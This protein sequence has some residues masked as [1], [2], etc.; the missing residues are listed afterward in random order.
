MTSDIGFCPAC[1]GKV[2]IQPAGHPASPQPVLPD[3]WLCSVA[4]PKPSVE[5]L[6]L[7]GTRPNIEVLLGRVG[8]GA[9][10]GRWCT[11]GGFMNIGDE[12]E[13]ALIRECRRELGASVEVG[14]PIGAFTDSFA[15]GEMALFYNCAIKSGEPGPKD[16]VD[17]VDWFPITSPPEMSLESE[18]KA[19][20]AMQERR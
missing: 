10:K 7:R 8:N 12:P 17:A 20:R 1:A 16:I 13:A 2:A 4:N 19:I 9:R 14:E 3:L 5:A 11:P 18:Q 6:I 15:G